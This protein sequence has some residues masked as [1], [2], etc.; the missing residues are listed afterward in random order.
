MQIALTWTASTDDVGVVGYRVYR[1]ATQVGTT[2]YTAYND[3]GLSASTAYSYQVSAFDA[4]G[5]ESARS[6]MVGAVTLSGAASGP[7]A[8][9]T[10][11][12]GM[13][14]GSWAQLTVPNQNAILGVGDHD[15]SMLPFSNAMPWNPR[16]HV[17]EILGMDHG[18]PAMRHARYDEASNQFVLVADDAGV[19]QGHGMDHVSLNPT[20]GDLYYR[21]YGGFT[22]TITVKRKP[23]GATSFT[24]TTTVSA[25]EQV[26]LGTTWWSGTFAGAGAQGAYM[27][28]N[29]GNALDTATDGNM[30]GYDPLTNTWF[31]NKTGVAPFYGSGSTYNGVMEYSAVKNVAA[32]GGGNVAPQKLWRLNADGSTTAMPDVPAGK[33][34]GL[35]N[36]N[37]VADPASGNFLLLSAGQLWELNPSG[38]GTWTQQTGT[39][40]PPADVGVPGPQPTIDDMISCAISDYGVVAYIKQKEQ[41]GATFYLYKHQ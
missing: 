2:T 22:G 23:F 11:A 14:P 37:L 34:V 27:I 18:Y 32:Y 28:F 40:A 41:N 36:G 1:G 31:M 12:S 19:G 25:L 39:R 6:S 4:A 3:V 26:S 38:A 24:D 20:T 13:S 35:Q 33:A 8:L 7:S 21:E 10:L 16:S 29:T 15:G 9:Q 17:I 30:L 5:N